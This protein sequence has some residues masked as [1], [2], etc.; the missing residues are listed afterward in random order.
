MTFDRNEYKVMLSRLEKQKRELE[1]PRPFKEPEES[2]KWKYEPPPEPKSIRKVVYDSAIEKRRGP[3]G[4][5]RPLN[6]QELEER[7]EDIIGEYFGGPFAA[8]GRIFRNQK[9]RRQADAL[10]RAMR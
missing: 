4:R 9:K 1:D 7:S 6:E 2:P 10:E 3:D 8:L 5:I